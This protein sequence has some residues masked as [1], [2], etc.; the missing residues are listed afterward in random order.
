[1][2]NQ[3]VI[4]VMPDAE[5]WRS[6]SRGPIVAMLMQ[7]AAEQCA[8]RGGENIE[9]SDFARAAIMVTPQNC[10][11]QIPVETLDQSPPEYRAGVWPNRI[12]PA[13]RAF[14]EMIWKAPDKVNDDEVVARA[15]AS[16]P[17]ELFDFSSV[18]TSWEWQPPA[19]RDVKMAVAKLPGMRLRLRR[20]PNQ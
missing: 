17:S 13:A 20:R 9:L 2:A 14:Y 3:E 8:I 16:I 15:V 18:S 7:A 11:V 10:P 6:P 5:G 1:M 12:S 4:E 19:G